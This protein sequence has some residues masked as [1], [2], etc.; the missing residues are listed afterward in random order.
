LRALRK[1]IENLRANIINAIVAPVSRAGGAIAPR[2]FADAGISARLD[3]RGQA[4]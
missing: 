4:L 3:D 1:D 2:C